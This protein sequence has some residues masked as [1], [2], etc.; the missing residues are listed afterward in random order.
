MD[1]EKF[2]EKFPEL[3][4][5]NMGDLRDSY[6]DYCEPEEIEEYCLSKQR[7]K[8]AI[9]TVKRIIGNDYQHNPDIKAGVITGLQWLEI[10]LGVKK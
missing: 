8:E 4:I 1:T 3:N 10:K 5:Y 2:E 9:E 6:K 7:V